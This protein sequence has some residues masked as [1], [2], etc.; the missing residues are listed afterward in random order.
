MFGCS[1][2]CRQI[3]T[4]TITPK[5]SIT[6]PLLT[7]INDGMIEDALNKRIIII[8]KNLDFSPMIPQ[9][10]AKTLL[11]GFHPKTWLLGSACDQT[12][13]IDDIFCLVCPCNT[14]WYNNKL[15]HCHYLD[16]ILLP[17]IESNQIN[18]SNEHVLATKKLNFL[19]FSTATCKMIGTR[20]STKLLKVLFDSGCTKTL[21]HKSTLQRN[22]KCVP[23]VDSLSFQTLG[24]KTTSSKLFMLDHICFPEFNSNISIDFHVAYVSDQNC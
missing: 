9:E 24:G 23:N 14:Y 2:S 16:A 1:V 21:I 18:P 19:S 6:R 15:N 12:T 5:R 7:I 10:V 8:S 13:V 22:C 20:Q 3:I 17:E 4:I 11:D